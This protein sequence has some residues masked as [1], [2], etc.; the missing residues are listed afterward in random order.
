MP[1]SIRPRSVEAWK[2]VAGYAAAALLALAAAAAVFQLWRAD[3]RI[4]LYYSGDNLMG[5]MFVQNVLDTGS[6]YDNPRLGGPGAADMRDYPI[7]DILHIAVLRLLGLVCS[8]SGVVLNLFYLLAFPLT[9]VSAYFALRRLRLGRLAALVPAVLYACASYHF[10]R[11]R[12]HIFLCAY[13]LVPVMLWLVLRVY[14]GRGPFRRPLSWEAAGAA[15]VCVLTGLAGVYY[16]FFSCCL[17]LAAGAADG[18]RRRRWGVLAASVVPAVLVAGSLAAA[19]A[20]SI[21]YTMH[22]GRNPEIAQRRPAEADIYS[23]DICEMLMP[24]MRHR[25]GYLA[26]LRE[27]FFAA[28]RQ[29][30]GEAWADSLG[31]LASLG[32]LGLVA[33]FLWRRRRPGQRADDGL[34]YLVVVAAVLGTLGGLGCLF[35]FYVSPMIRCYSRLS[36]F[37]AFLALAGLFLGLQ[38]L[39]GRFVRGPL[40][41]AAYAAGLAV[42]LALGLL[43]QTSADFT[44]YYTANRK[45]FNSDED[46]GRRIEALLPAGSMVYQMPYVSFPENPPVNNLTDYELLRPFLHTRTLR[47]SYGAVRGRE[48]ARWQADLATRPLPEV[49]ETLALTGFR[50]VYLDRAGFADS[51][52]GTEEELSCLLGAEPLVSR[53]GRQTF[54]DMTEFAE[55]LR[56]RF[57]DAEWEA[58]RDAVLHPVEVRWEGGFL[59]PEQGP[60]GAWRWCGPRGELHVVNASRTSRRVVLRMECSSLWDAAAPAQFVVDGAAGRRELPLGA[61][62]RPLELDMR[63]PTGDH[64]IHFSYDGPCQTTPNGAVAFRVWNAEWRVEDLP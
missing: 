34:A 14:L 35:S 53:N 63:A 11:C 56:S 15:L 31:A 21:L 5:Q 38:R 33:R 23:L 58:R 49:V 60:E 4:P 26:H 50:G 17:L 54:F 3:P 51:G 16:A 46:F 7:P 6:V 62:R 64:V 32:F 39:A 8:D 52:A 45:E 61:D 29:A 30:T 25:I 2:N 57:T 36:I 41:K 55:A 13:Y 47:W 40:T 59:A 44:P 37:I 22:A 43:D 28:P 48:A 42:L 10:L 12:G 20:P 1:P 18:V 9:A 27:Q 19:L 24:V